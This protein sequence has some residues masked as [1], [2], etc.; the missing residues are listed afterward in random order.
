MDSEQWS[1]WLARWHDNYSPMQT[2]EVVNALKGD[3]CFADLLPDAL[4]SSFR[5]D[6]KSDG[7]FAMTLGYHLRAKTGTPF[8]TR[9]L[10]VMHKDKHKPV[11]WMIQERKRT[12]SKITLPDSEHFGVDGVNGVDNSADSQL[13]QKIENRNVNEPVESDE[14]NN[15]IQKPVQNTEIGFQNNDTENRISNVCICTDTRKLSTPLTLSTQN[16]L[17][18]ERKKLLRKQHASPSNHHKRT[19]TEPPIGMVKVMPIPK[20]E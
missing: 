13:I 14:D 8:G 16:V 18:E 12:V 3:Q 1:A 9:Q 4:G 17:E 15:P 11:T 2:R 20:V 6:K 10:T 19:S 5:D 7:Q